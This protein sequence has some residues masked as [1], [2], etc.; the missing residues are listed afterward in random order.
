MS[1]VLPDTA[2]MH[3]AL[4]QDDA[5]AW[6]KW[7]HCTHLGCVLSGC[8]RD[9]QHV[10]VRMVAAGLAQIQEALKGYQLLALQGQGECA[11]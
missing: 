8:S 3:A 9:G 2:S 4:R 1:A 11:S 10:D 7:V 5:R 6:S